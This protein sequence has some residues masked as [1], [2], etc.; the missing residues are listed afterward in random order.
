MSKCT[1][2]VCDCPTYLN[3]PIC[4]RANMTYDER[5]F[6]AGRQQGREDREGECQFLD[7]EIARLRKALPSV[8][9][10]TN[11]P[12]AGTPTY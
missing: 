9:P 7:E 4:Q 8:I 12:D 3:T 2:P 11:I 10:G 6:F 1:F 5:S